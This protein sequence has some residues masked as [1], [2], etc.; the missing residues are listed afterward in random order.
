MGRELGHS[1]DLTEFHVYD[2]CSAGGGFQGLNQ[3]CYS[4]TCE[5]MHR[6]F[7][8]GQGANIELNAP[9][10][11]CDGWN[12]NPVFFGLAIIPCDTCNSACKDRIVYCCGPTCYYSPSGPNRPDTPPTAEFGLV[13]VMHDAFSKWIA[14]NWHRK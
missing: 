1:V 4:S 5:V 2:E 7:S 9:G 14:S 11:W 12:I 6:N 3:C 10:S 13:L 8:I